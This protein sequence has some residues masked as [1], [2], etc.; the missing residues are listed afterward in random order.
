[1]TD[2]L[3]IKPQ[4]KRSK[5]SLERLL[6]ASA[7][8]I[9]AGNFETVSVAE[10]TRQANCSVGTFYGR[11]QNKAALFH[12]VQQ[13]VFEKALAFADSR[14]ADFI[15]DVSPSSD[16]HPALRSEL[17]AAG[18]AIDLAVDL[19]SEN[20]GIFR[21]IFLHT[22]TLQDPALMERVQQFNAACMQASIRILSAT[23]K[24]QSPAMIKNW[25]NGFEIIVVYLRESILFGNPVD[26]G[27]PHNLAAMKSVAAGMFSAYLSEVRQR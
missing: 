8:Q 22:R 4:Q 7:Q 16:T 14:I 27:S 24:D 26:T 3:L 15:S 12:V 18:F 2:T 13:R 10:I 9:A 5:Q 1:M 6:N 21:A 25:Q 11:F 23:G 20:R 17:D 19:Y